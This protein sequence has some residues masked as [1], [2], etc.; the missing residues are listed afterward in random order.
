MSQTKRPRKKP[1]M[2]QYNEEDSRVGSGEL[3]KKRVGHSVSLF[4]FRSVVTLGPVPCSIFHRLSL[5][6]KSGLCVFSQH[7]SLI[8]FKILIYLFTIDIER[9]RQRYRQRKKQAAYQEP[10][11]GLDPGTPGSHL[12]PKAGVKPLSHPGCPCFCFCF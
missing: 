12:G 2:F 10:D 3:G 4:V 1:V 7:L 11:V 9:E 6:P 8:F 5:L